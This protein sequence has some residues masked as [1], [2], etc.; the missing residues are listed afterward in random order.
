MSHHCGNFTTFHNF[1]AVAKNGILPKTE[2]EFAKAL[3][4]PGLILPDK[5]KQIYQILIKMT[6][7]NP[8]LQICVIDRDLDE[9]FDPL[10]CCLLFVV[11]L[12]VALHIDR[13]G[14]TC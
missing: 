8:N 5:S 1:Y 4:C 6:R 3:L 2:I 7:K 9:P 12:L 10:L 14:I 13:L 11:C